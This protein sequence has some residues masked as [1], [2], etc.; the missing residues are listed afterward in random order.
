MWAGAH[1]TRHGLIAVIPAIPET[2]EG[3]WDEEVQW[4]SEL[5]DNDGA[6]PARQRRR[7]WPWLAGVP[8]VLVLA[9]AFGSGY[10]LRRT[11]HH[12]LAAATAVA[13]RD[14]PYWRL[15]DLMAHREAVPDAENS[16]LV[17]AAALALLPRKWPTG[18]A[19]QPG[20]PTPSIS[21][22]EE[23]LDRLNATE[24]TIRLDDAAAETLRAELHANAEAVRIARTV[25]GFSRGRHELIL[26]PNL[27]DTVVPETQVA[28]TAA[29]LL[30]ADA[31]IRAHDGDLDG[32][33]DSCRA[34]LGVGR[35]IGDEPFLSSQLVR[36]AI[37]RAVAMKS[38]RRALGQGEPSDAALARLQALIADE[39]GQ[40][41][42]IHGL[43]GERAI[44][45][46]LIG[47]FAVGEV[48]WNR[49]KFDYQR[50]I[51][52]EWM[53]EVVAIARQPAFA[54]PPLWE[55]L[56]AKVNGVKQSR[57]GASTASLPIELIPAMIQADRV[58]ALYQAELGAMVLLLAAERQ[59]LKTGGWPASIAAIDVRILP[60]PPVDPFSGQAFRME[61]RD[62]QLFVYSIGPNRM[63]E[64][65]A[66]DERRW[67]NGGPDDAGGSAWDVARRGQ[68]P[69]AR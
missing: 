59:R 43:K 10:Y 57:L 8:L 23:V 58:D 11:V 16:A 46:A 24:D 69:S 45:N 47:R 61:H 36:M 60:K 9:V 1:P 53:N 17:V 44:S 13:D 21:R 31:A 22:A 14:D 5:L 51:T 48:P 41:V 30:A 56:E 42:L 4:M 25:A 32:A 49:L 26:G 28:R 35:S 39:L 68:A 55:T 27:F 20:G 29:R 40:P 63:D 2:D 52:L 19:P 50:A 64:H 33:L 38:T 6:A 37:G 67:L 7:L 18:P 62:G 65:G 3:L 66:F 15:D 34:I 54:R 12:R